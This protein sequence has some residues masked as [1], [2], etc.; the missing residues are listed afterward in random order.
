MKRAL[1]TLGGLFATYSAVAA[2]AHHR[3]S[4]AWR[5]AGAPKPPLGYGFWFKSPAESFRTAFGPL[6]PILVWSNTAEGAASSGIPLRS[7]ELDPRDL[8]ERVRSGECRWVQI[9]QSADYEAICS[10]GGI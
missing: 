8:G 7:A 6:D 1:I 9:G 2:V 10:G 5:E 3:S 4:A